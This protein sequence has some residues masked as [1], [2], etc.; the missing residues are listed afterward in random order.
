M[1]C[2]EEDNMIKAVLTFWMGPVIL[3]ALEAKHAVSSVSSDF[4][5]FAKE[6]KDSLKQI[7]DSDY[8]DT[9]VVGLLMKISVCEVYVMDHRYDG[10]YRLVLV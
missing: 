1:K 3:L 4:I 2:L 5:K 10:L 7:R 8:K 9:P 6:L